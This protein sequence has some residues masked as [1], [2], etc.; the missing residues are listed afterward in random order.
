M[1]DKLQILEDEHVV[2]IMLR[3][4]RKLN[5]IDPEMLTGLH[6]AIGKVGDQNHVRAVIISGEGERAFSAG[7]D[8]KAWAALDALD[9]WRQWIPV[10]NKL[11]RQ[12]A[13]LPQPVIAAV[14]GIAFGG[15][16][17]LTLACDLRIASETAVFAMPEVSIATVPGWGGTFRL[18]AIIGLARA[19]AMILTGQRIDAATALDWGLITEIVPVDNIH[20]RARAMADQIAS[21]APLAVR[22]A[23]QLIDHRDHPENM[24]AIAGALGAHTQDGQEGIQSFREK[25]PPKYGGT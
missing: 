13:E 18:P 2:S 20:Q 23:K 24:E 4:P 7:A 3:R 9:M 12:I 16:L 19:K 8:I 6:E 1:T 25:R 11:M 14:N 10:G 22:M 5:A 21:N 17:E 15:G